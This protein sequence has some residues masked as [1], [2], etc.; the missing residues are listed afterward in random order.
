MFEF[1]RIPLVL[2][3]AAALTLGS[4]G[5]GDETA[6]DNPTSAQTQTT[7]TTET[8]DT[9][10]SSGEPK[11]NPRAKEIIACLRQKDMFTIVNPGTSVGAEYH[12][13]IDNGTGGIIYGF[14]DEATA[15]ASKGKVDKD[16]GSAGR[17][18]EVIGD[19]TYSTFPKGD[20]FAAPEKT[21]KARACAGA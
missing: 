5:G 16:Q 15:K 2:V 6:E 12:L 13:V 7:P 19:V 20:E 18:T 21:P 4:C 17:K 14:K 1:R 11:N 10:T 8:A 9:A 3:T